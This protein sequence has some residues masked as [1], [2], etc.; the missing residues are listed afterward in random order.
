M[1]TMITTY[2]ARRKAGETW[3][4]VPGQQP[5]Q[6][7]E[8]AAARFDAELAAGRPVRMARRTVMDEDVRR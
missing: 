2:L 1:L 3:V 5:G 6:T 7:R 8:E 4:D